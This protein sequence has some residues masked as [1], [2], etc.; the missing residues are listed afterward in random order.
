[1]GLY[2]FYAL[3]GLLAFVL[4]VFY[5][6]SAQRGIDW[7]K[8][9][10]NALD[11]LIHLFLRY[12]HRAKWQ[13]IDLPEHG[14]ALVVA[15]HV[16]G[17]DPLLLIAASP[18]PLRFL[19]AAEQYDRF[20]LHIFF[21]SADAIRVDRDHHPERAVRQALQVLNKGEVVM[22]FPH[23]HIHLDSDAPHD[24]KRGAV[25]LSEW[26]GAP[27]YPCR[28]DGVKGEGDIM[29]ALYK[30]GQPRLSIAAPLSC[31]KEREQQCYDSLLA[32]IENRA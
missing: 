8:P 21:R 15:N 28:I 29:L 11:G 17:L 32:I 7:G 19:I 6:L 16:S 3:S 26:S 1:M 25:K 13:R 9:G 12:Y 23:G 20:F 10:L 30:R 14:P 31:E 18:R 4:L 22:I 24:I 27:I 5:L 2:Y